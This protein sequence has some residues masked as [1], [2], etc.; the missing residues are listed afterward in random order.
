MYLCLY[1]YDIKSVIR[2][3][4]GFRG[5]AHATAICGAINKRVNAASFARHPSPSPSSLYPCCRCRRRFPSSA[6]GGDVF[7]VS[8]PATPLLPGTDKQSDLVG[9]G[10]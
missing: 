4:A 2:R 7:P 1:E 3:G 6:D 10:D 5:A 9:R 8:P